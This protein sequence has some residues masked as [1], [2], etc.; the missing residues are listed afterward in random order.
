M[1]GKRWTALRAIFEEIVELPP[2]DRLIDL[3]RL[4]A[5]DAALRAEL[6]SLLDAHDESRDFLEPFAGAPAA[7]GLDEALVGEQVGAYRIE[8]E[9]AAGGMGIVYAARQESPRRRVA[10]KM[11]RLDLSA[12]DARRRFEYESEILGRLQHPGIARIFEA[13]VHRV[14]IG[15]QRLEV[16]FFAMEFVE[17]AKTILAHADESNLDPD[18]RIRLFMSVCDAVHHGHQ[19][20]VIHRDLKPSNIL[21]DRDGQPRVIDFGIAR[22]TDAKLTRTG[23]VRQ[24]I[25]TLH[26]MSPEQLSGDPSSIDV[27]TDVYGLGLVLYE[28]VCGRPPHDLS[29]KPLPEVARI[30]NEQGP[31]RPSSVRPGLPPELDWILLKALDPE[32]NQRYGSAAAL[33]ADLNR[34]LENEPVL[35][36]PPGTAYRVKKFVRRH[37]ASVSAVAAIILTLVI[38]LIVSLAQYREA[39]REERNASAINRYLDRWLSSVD[40]DQEGRD[41]KMVDLLQGALGE[42]EASFK[43]QPFIRSSL[44]HTI[45]SALS[46]LGHYARAEPPL[47]TALITRRR[48]LGAGH[49]LTLETAQRLGWTLGNLDR[50]EEGEALLRAALAVG[51][52]RLGEDDR[53][54]LAC[55]ETLGVV[56][57]N[58]ARYEEAERCLRQTLARQRRTLG[59]NHDDTLRCLADLANLLR[60]A[61]RLDEAESLAREALTARTRIR[62]PD[63]SET[64]ASR[65][66]LAAVLNDR[67]RYAEAEVLLREALEINERKLGPG[68]LATC[69][70]KRALADVLR[71]QEKLEASETLLREVVR[72]ELEERGEAHSDTIATMND[73]GVT[74]LDEGKFAEAETLYRRLLGATRRVFGERD[75]RCAKTMGNLALALKKQNKLAEAEPLYAESLA[76]RIAIFGEEHPDTLTVMHNL[77]ALLTARKKYGEACRLYEKILA[78]RVAL[79]GEDHPRTLTSRHNLV[80]VLR[81]LGRLEEAEKLARESAAL[82]RRALGVDNLHTH[83]ATYRLALVLRQAGKLEKA[84]AVFGELLELAEKH[85]GRGK[86]PTENT[87]YMYGR[88]LTQLERA[89]EAETPLLAGY[90]IARDGLGPRHRTTLRWAKAVLE[91]YEA[92]GQ[93]EKATS[94]RAALAAG[95]PVGKRRAAEGNRK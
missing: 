95:S 23:S 87:R 30:L 60:I 69:K 34:Y 32:P 75:I 36:G 24:I 43:G 38:G 12:P 90:R 58:R 65:I 86:E 39:R 94:F 82:H 19:K 54:V 68:H 21:V 85:I 16:P 88:C 7:S 80:G 42:I 89:S 3:D 56:L 72:R 26:Y 79:L 71:F 61:G 20:G 78:G 25:G 57:K 93:N 49:P 6:V 40:P 31:T 14:S 50:N 70:S 51:R 47:R 28:L 92:S 15:G 83:L 73:L 62:G 53:H 11:M 67:G 10:L 91:L 22:V 13:G 2:A 44:D 77:A 27:R 17:D 5:G 4:C 1:N 66:V 59:S 63:H 64:Q 45:G 74:L 52:R 33:A 76:L 41:V 84:T 48:L 81:K 8:E 9:I 46:A 35:A 37:R 29:E 55:L 18:E